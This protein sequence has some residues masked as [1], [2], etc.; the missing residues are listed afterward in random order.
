MSV[1]LAFCFNL[2][3]QLIYRLALYQVCSA[4]GYGVTCAFDVIQVPFIQNGNR[5]QVNHPLCYISSFLT[6]YTLL[7]K[8]LFTL[9]MTIHLFFF[10]VFYKN[11]RKLEV[12][13]VLTALVLPLLAAI[14]PFTTDTYGQ[15]GR[16]SPWCWITVDAIDC[17][18]ATNHNGV[19]EVFSL[20]LGPAVVCL[21]IMF[22]LVCI[23]I[24]V[25][26]FRIYQHAASVVKNRLALKQMMPL[27][28]YP[29]VYCA[30]VFVT[31]VHYIYD[32]I[33]GSH[34]SETAFSISDELS[35][36]GYVWTAG[37]TFLIH[38]LVVKT[39]MKKTKVDDLG[40]N[41]EYLGEESRLIKPE[42]IIRS[43]TY[44]SNKTEG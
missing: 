14:V 6:T 15:S 36:T 8:L 31:V 32:A 21:V 30:L 27:L 3:R 39:S 28:A 38:I 25:L 40:C 20:W 4:F 18:D 16:G 9:V 37:L 1:V 7:A 29:V 22:T 35:F 41:S 26:V 23:L 44:A 2:H 17:S 12:W 11:L 42:V 19:L 33:P 43:S 10:T 5:G 13:Y 24:G 34:T